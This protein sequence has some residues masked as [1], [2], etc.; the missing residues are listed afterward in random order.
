[1]PL[2][3]SEL[4]DPNRR[5][6]PKLPIP[7]PKGTVIGNIAIPPA[8]VAEIQ[9]IALQKGVDTKQIVIQLFKMGLLAYKL[10]E[11]GE[12]FYVKE[13]EGYVKVTLDE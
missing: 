1:M 6:T 7:S 13:G 12:T 10:D 2:I 9:Q 3:P 5:V 8:L 4:F 11:R